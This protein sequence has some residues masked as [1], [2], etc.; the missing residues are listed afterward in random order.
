[1]QDAWTINN[2]LT[3]NARPP[4]RAR[5]GSVLCSRPGRGRRDAAGHRPRVRFQGQAG[6][7]RG[8]RLRHQRRR[9][10]EGVRLVGRVLRHL[11]ARTA[12]R[13]VRRRQVDRVLL[14]A[15]HLQLADARGQPGVP[16]RVPRQAAPHD[17]LPAHLGRPERD[18]PGPQADAAAGSD[19]RHRA[20]VERRDVAQRPLRPQAGRPRDRGHADGHPR[21][22]R[23][24]DLHHREPGRGAG[25]ARVLGPGG[26]ESEA[27][28]RLR[29]R[30]VRRSRSGSRRTG[31]CG[32]ATSG[33][34][35]S[36]TTRVSPSRTRTGAPA[37]TS[38]VCGTTR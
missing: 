29:Q 38:A 21:R 23:Q 19:R 9:P 33:A 2:R 32:R 13:I 7:A 36:A 14:H 15:R 25:G 30:G 24:R 12:A 27:G 35:C 34:G 16:A 10:L 37:R 3:I 31:T 5:A 17:R 6:A 20:P 18:R 26:E 28:A 1:M 22:G 11:Q 8:L 4:H